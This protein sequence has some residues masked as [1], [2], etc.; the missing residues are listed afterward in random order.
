LQSKHIISNGCISQKECCIS[1]AVVAIYCS[2]AGVKHLVIFC[3]LKTLVN[4]KAVLSS[5][6]FCSFQFSISHRF[7]GCQEVSERLAATVF[8]A[9]FIQ[10]LAEDLD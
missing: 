3:V 7:C 5:A 9:E 2:C 10:V 1:A 8:R 4:F 6:F